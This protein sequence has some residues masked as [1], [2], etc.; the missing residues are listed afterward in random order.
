MTTNLFV[1]VNVEQLRTGGSFRILLPFF[2]T[3]WGDGVLN[4]SIFNSFH[5]RVEFG[6]I[7]EGLRNFGGGGVEPPQT[8][9][10]Y[11]TF[12]HYLTNAAIC[13]N[14][15]MKTYIFYFFY[16]FVQNISHS[17]KN[18]ARYYRQRT[19]VFTQ[20]TRYSCQILMK[21]EFY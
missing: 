3:S 2:R 8:P 14:N 18:S 11:A 19:L 20:S 7:L 12:P 10:R 9:P 15:L 17:K 4:S 5:N 16:N 1:I 6:A 21:L 13:G